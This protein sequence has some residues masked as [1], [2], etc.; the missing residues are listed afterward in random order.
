MIAH[1]YVALYICHDDEE[2]IREFLVGQGIPRRTVRR[3]LHLTV[4]HA[5]FPL[6]GLLA[7][8]ERIDIKVNVNETRFMPMA[9]G[10]ETPRPHIDP[11]TKKVGIRLTNRN[12]AIPAIKEARL[13]FAQLE[14]PA[15]L[16]DRPCSTHNRNA[17]GPRCFRPHVTLLYPGSQVD[18]DLTPLGEAFRS[19]HQYLNFD[20]LVVRVEEPQKPK[21]F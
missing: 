7:M 9:L 10:G 20:R 15:L 21:R 17:F 14:T 5:D 8:E 2:D 12:E 13:R 4:Y 18:R 11:A 6:P 19:E 3:N 16:G 1:T